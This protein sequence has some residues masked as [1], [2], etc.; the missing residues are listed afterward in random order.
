MKTIGYRINILIEF[1]SRSKL[2]TATALCLIF[3]AIYFA[4]NGFTI[5]SPNDDYCVFKVIY[6]GNTAIPCIGIFYTALCVILQPFFSSLNVYM[7][8]QEA[9]CFVSLTAVNYFFLAKSGAKKGLVFAFVFDI[10]YFS[11]LII[12][13]I[14]TYTSVV[15]ATAGFLCLIYGGFYEN[16]R[17]YKITQIIT[18][19]ILCL[20]GSQLR[21][22]PF[23]TCCAI[24]FALFASACAVFIYKNIKRSGVKTALKQFFKKYLLTGVLLFAAVISAFGLN[25]FSDALKYSDSAFKELSEYYSAYSK[26]TDS[27]SSFWYF[28]QEEMSKADIKSKSDLMTCNT[29]FVDDDFFTIKRLTKISETYKKDGIIKNNAWDYIADIFKES[30]EEA[31]RSGMLIL[32]IFLLIIAV[33]TIVFIFIFNPAAGK[34]AFRIGLSLLL[35]SVCFFV[36]DV[37]EKAVIL[38]PFVAF[39]LYTAIR[40][41]GRQSIISFSL[42]IS[43]LVFYTYLAGY[44]LLFYTAFAVIY[45]AF[46]FM[47][48]ALDESNLLK[49]KKR[50]KL[51]KRAAVILM[52]LTIAVSVCSGVIKIQQDYPADTSNDNRL[53]EEYITENPDS[54]FLVN[55]MVLKRPYY[56][57]LVLPK[58]HKNVVNYGLWLKKA[59]Y[60][61]RSGEDNGLKHL[62]KDSIDRKNAYIIVY[63]DSIS[64]NSGKPIISC[65][66]LEEYYNNHYAEKGKTIKLYRAD[67]VGN[68]S[69]YNVIT[70]QSDK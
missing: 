15:A 10:V 36:S 53:I 61:K 54:V 19:F 28:N 51:S 64:D 60:F 41:N 70:Q 58:E 40:Y 7:L 48:F 43:F 23:E 27:R 49:A 6:G 66:Y 16:R 56:N 1:I 38:L 42:I 8:L 20:L 32:Y 18:G 25:Y 63:E 13:I 46:V 39:S 9:V 33:F 31:F 59:K 24:C 29:W 47:I 35:W 68:Y 57:P 30:A 11:F 12:S 21:F 65:S 67:R 14:F 3:S 5:T 52:A 17:R 37:I 62:F 69:L 55:Q 45:P 22:P 26:V 2:I 34:I 50:V 44:R 4:L